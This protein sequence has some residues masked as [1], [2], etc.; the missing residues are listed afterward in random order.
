MERV[1]AFDLIHIIY[2]LIYPG[3]LGT[4]LYEILLS[5]Q[6]FGFWGC[7]GRGATL[8]IFG[9]DFMWGKKFYEQP[10]TGC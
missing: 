9:L 1:I 3:F 10:L 7:A 8:L 6:K 2:N 4:F 5:K